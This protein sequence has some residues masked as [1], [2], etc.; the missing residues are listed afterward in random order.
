M[1]GD[2]AAARSMFERACEMTEETPRGFRP[3]AFLMLA[4]LQHADDP[5]AAM[6]SVVRC[7]EIAP[8]LSDGHFLH[9][10][11]LAERGEFGAARAAFEESIATGKYA[12]QQFVVDDK[13]RSGRQPTR[14]PES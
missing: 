2:L 12:R 7:T 13:S 4:K 3:M 14:S 8:T 1:A 5:A 6:R 10:K 11:L 9:G